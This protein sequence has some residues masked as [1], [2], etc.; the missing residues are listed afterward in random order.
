[1]SGK[2]SI[3]LFTLLAAAG[4][5]L[6]CG[7]CQPQETIRSG[8]NDGNKRVQFEATVANIYRN[9]AGDL[10]GKVVFR[11]ESDCPV[12][13][14]LRPH[15]VG[16]YAELQLLPKGITDPLVVELGDWGR[17]QTSV[18]HGDPEEYVLVY[19]M[20]ESDSYS[21]MVKYTYETDLVLARK[22]D[23]GK[24][25]ERTGRTGGLASVYLSVHLLYV[26][27]LP[28]IV[29]GDAEPLGRCAL[30]SLMIKKIIDFDF[31]KAGDVVLV[32]QAGQNASAMSR[33]AK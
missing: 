19:G 25:A 10:C 32:S 31:T 16:Y 9:A 3:G 21:P 14:A 17:I 22:Q 1:M 4:L 18:G 12:L 30:G 20:K 23:L 27:N 8:S 24:I 11:N 5:G 2:N 26:E 15:G 7:G 28:P 29:N 6:F 33:P 13:L